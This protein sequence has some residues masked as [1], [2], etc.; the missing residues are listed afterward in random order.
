MVLQ[1][2]K[3]GHLAGDLG[4]DPLRLHA[5]RSAFRL[6]PASDAQRGVTREAQLQRARKDMQLAEVSKGLR[7][8]GQGGYALVLR[9]VA[10]CAP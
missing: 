10:L 4:F 7:D 9:A 1:A 2:E 5:L 6:D 3:S 8:G